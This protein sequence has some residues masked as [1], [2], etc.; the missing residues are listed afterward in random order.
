MQVRAGEYETVYSNMPAT[1]LG[2]F[3]E[4]V[5]IEDQQSTKQ[6]KPDSAHES[7]AA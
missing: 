4:L 2:R 1:G 3:T 5:P 7:P 6:R